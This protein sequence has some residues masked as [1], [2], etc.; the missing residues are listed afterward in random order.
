M[1]EIEEAIKS[2]LLAVTDVSALLGTRFYVNEL[3]Q[4]PTYPAVIYEISEQERDETMEG[5]SG[6]VKTSFEFTVY[7]DDYSGLRDLVT[8]IRRG[9]DFE[10]SIILGI[11]LFSTFLETAPTFFD[12]DLEVNSAVMSFSV[13]HDEVV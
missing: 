2:K 1:S 6:L 8:K 11:T 5:P 12:D 13:W 3:P 7:D 4:K 10:R 9:M